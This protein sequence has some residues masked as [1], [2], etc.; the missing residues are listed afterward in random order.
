[1]NDDVKPS[2]WGTPKGSTFWHRKVKG[3]YEEIRLK[4]NETLPPG[5]WVRG[6]TPKS[7]E[8]KQNISDA[9]VGRKMTEEWRAKMSAA[10][11]G[12]K[13]S[14]EH[15]AAMKAALIEYH[16]KRKAGEV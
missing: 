11:K 4:P 6:H 1:M 5:V 16:R 9:L 14:P 13:K 2:N 15:V 8:A 3:V 7:P 12:R 10:S